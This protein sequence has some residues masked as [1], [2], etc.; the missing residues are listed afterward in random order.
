M[1]SSSGKPNSADQHF[2]TLWLVLLL[3][4][5]VVP[6]RIGAAAPELFVLAMLGMALLAGTGAL[7]L[8]SSRQHPGPRLHY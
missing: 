2:P 7:A 4:A 3:I 6:V 1:K 5:S 8:S